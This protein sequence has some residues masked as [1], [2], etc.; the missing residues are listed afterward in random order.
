MAEGMPDWHIDAEPEA[1][2]ETAATVVMERVVELSEHEAEKSERLLEIVR[3]AIEHFNRGRLGAALTL[4]DL[5]DRLLVTLPELAYR[6]E[7]DERGRLRWRG[8]LDGVEVIETSEPLASRW[9]RFKA[10][11]L[12]IVPNSQL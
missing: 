9:L 10:F 4:F 11:L 8:Q 3:T 1:Q 5:A 6:V 7:R 12:K 2:P